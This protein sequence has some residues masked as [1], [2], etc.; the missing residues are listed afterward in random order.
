[1]SNPGRGLNPQN[2]RATAQGGSGFSTTGF[3]LK[4]VVNS[5]GSSNSDGVYSPRRHTISPREEPNQRSGTVNSDS[6]GISPRPGATPPLSSNRPAKPAPEKVSPRN[7]EVTYDEFGHIKAC[8]FPKLIEIITFDNPDPQLMLVMFY[9][10]RSFSTGSQELLS[11][12]IARERASSSREIKIRV[13]NVITHW[14]NKFW[15]DFEK[16]CPTLSDMLLDWLNEILAGNANN[17]IVVGLKTRLLSSLSSPPKINTPSFVDSTPPPPLKPANVNADITYWNAV[18]IARQITLVD[19]KLW[20]AIKMH[21]FYNLGWARKE[22]ETTSKNVLA[23]ITRLN[24]ISHWVTG[25]IC[26]C[27]ALDERVKVMGKFIEIAYQ[28][29]KMNNFNGLLS[30]LS[31]LNNGAVFRLKKSFTIATEQQNKKD[32]NFASLLEVSSSDH[33]YAALRTALKSVNPPVIPYLGMYLTDLTFIEEGSNKVGDNLI[34]F[35]KRRKFAQVLMEIKTYQEG[36]GYNFIELPE[37][38][39]KMKDPLISEQDLYD[40]S[41]FLEPREGKPQPPRPA[42]LDSDASSSNIDWKTVIESNNHSIEW[43]E[44]LVE[45]DSLHIFWVVIIEDDLVKVQKSRGTGQSDGQINCRICTRR[46]SIFLGKEAS[47]SY[48]LAL[49]SCEYDIRVAYKLLQVFAYPELPPKCAIEDFLKHIPT[50]L[51]SLAKMCAAPRNEPSALKSDQQQFGPSLED[52]MRLPVNKDLPVPRLVAGAVSAILSGESE[53]VF[54]AAGSQTR[55]AEMT[56][57]LNRGD[58]VDFTIEEVLDVGS[59]LKQFA[60]ILPTPLCPFE[61]YNRFLDCDNL[62]EESAKVQ[63]LREAIEALPQLH[64]HVLLAIIDLLYTLSHKVASADSELEAPIRTFSKLWAST[65]FKNK[66]ETSSSMLADIPRIENTLYR[67]IL[68]RLSLFKESPSEVSEMLKTINA[69]NA[70]YFS[71]E[72]ISPLPNALTNSASSLSP[73][74]S[75]SSTS[76]T[77][78]VTAPLIGLFTRSGKDKSQATIG[79]T[80]NA[81]TVSSPSKKRGSL[82]WGEDNILEEESDRER[83]GEILV[84]QYGA[85]RMINSYDTADGASNSSDGLVLE[86]FSSPGFGR[87][88]Q[89]EGEKKASIGDSTTSEFNDSS[90]DGSSISNGSSP[91]TVNNQNAPSIRELT[92]AEMLRQESFRFLRNP[93]SMDDAFDEVSHMLTRPYQQ[94]CDVRRTL[95]RTQGPLGIA[96][97]RSANATPRSSGEL[98][99]ISRENA[100]GNN[101]HEYAPSNLPPPVPLVS[102]ALT[103]IPPSTPLPAVPSPTSPHETPSSPHNALTTTNR[104]DPTSTLNH[105]ILKSVPLKYSAPTTSKIAITSKSPPTSP[106]ES[107]GRP[108]ERPQTSSN[109]KRDTLN[110]ANPNPNPNPNQNPNPN[111]NITT[112]PP[113]EVAQNVSGEESSSNSGNP[114]TAL[115]PA[116]AKV[117]RERRVAKTSSA[118]LKTFTLP[119]GQ[120]QQG[121]LLPPPSHALPAT[122]SNQSAQS[123]SPR[124]NPVSNSPRATTS[125]TADDVTSSG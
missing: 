12:L 118:C 46:A 91:P 13:Y 38:Q 53:G 47:V 15:Y 58:M 96:G 16:D 112:N 94:S 117:Q 107:W 101:S 102:P 124:A 55:V 108:E 32:I 110:L 98:K 83:D 51:K 78:S 28:L 31:G 57:I 93:D 42:L 77:S 125:T 33:A 81:G 34:N 88:S 17:P 76:S 37:M 89:R 116:I 115:N 74:T 4:P 84:H 41:Y 70:D 54:Q 8:T 2:K 105:R 119:L 104:P 63:G 69:S 109:N 19:W 48:V 9:T 18:E 26:L 97:N 22:K 86:R 64:Y 80:F 1:M 21:E 75:S 35:F 87:S 14:I 30:I 92:D 52:V 103:T 56:R 121:S 67:M 65:L 113:Q 5:E 59:V 49:A 62:A 60:R 43:K 36:R 111:P 23:M 25:T 99:L 106:R 24:E 122:P 45:V 10:Y 40:L 20:I 3:T 68:N 7:L 120:Q 6:P 11:L 82:F 114:A 66:F 71:T 61:M 27:E 85:V 44:A 79:R 95:S 39:S 72:P 73:S 50:F 29:R 90:Q 123:P 100:R